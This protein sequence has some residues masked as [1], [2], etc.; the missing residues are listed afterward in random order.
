MP[1]VARPGRALPADAPRARAGLPGHRAGHAG[2]GRLDALAQHRREPRGAPDPLGL[3]LPRAAGG[4]RHRRVA[5]RRTRRA[6]LTCARSSS[7]WPTRCAWRGRASSSR[8]VL[9]TLI[10]IGR[11]SRNAP[12]ARR[13]H[14]LRRA[15]AQRPADHPAVRLVP[16][17]HRAAAA[18]HRAGAH[19][20]RAFL[21]KSGL[22]FPLPEWA[23]GWSMAMAGAAVGSR[24][25]GYRQ[26]ARPPRAHRLSPS[27]CGRCC[28]CSSSRRSLGWLAGGAPASFDVPEIDTFDIIGGAAADAGVPVAAARAHRLHRRVHRRDRALGR[29]RGAARARRRPPAALGLSRALTLRLVLLP[30]ALRRHRPAAHQ[31][32]PE[33]HQELVAGRRDRLPRRRLD[34]QHDDQPERPGARVRAS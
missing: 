13:V 14:R 25:V 28:C 21:S 2:G 10:G 9:G 27:A 19:R 7:A 32:V 30:Q 6:T 17:D 3:R 5:V 22:Q 4:L 26:W 1:R 18:G 8:R 31:P 24:G 11:L 34:R 20:Q 15:P 23:P 33:P 12:A 16:R 29:A